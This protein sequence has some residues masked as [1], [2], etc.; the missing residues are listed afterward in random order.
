M[1]GRGRE[2]HPRG[3]ERSGGA[4]RRLPDIMFSVAT[5][6]QLST[7]SQREQH[8][9]VLVQAV[10]MAGPGGAWMEGWIER[11]VDEWDG[12]M[13]WEGDEEM[14]RWAKGRGLSG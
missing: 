4:Q 14:D 12:R 11:G 2:R 6:A 5:V 9:L 3:L 13:E 1:A 10:L 8:R 7:K